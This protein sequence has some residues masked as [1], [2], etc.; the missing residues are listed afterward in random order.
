AS[1][2]FPSH[3][4]L[5]S[6]TKISSTMSAAGG[7]TPTTSSPPFLK[8]KL[9][10]LIGIFSASLVLLCLA[11]FL[12]FRL[13]HLSRRRVK[14]SS[15][16]I[17]LV[18][19]E[20]N[21]KA[22]SIVDLEAAAA[23]PGKPSCTESSPVKNREQDEMPGGVNEL[24]SVEGWGRWYGLKELEKATRG[25]AAENVVGEGGYGVVYRGV[26]A[27]G[28]VVAVKNLL[29]NK[30]QAEKEFEVEVEAIGKVRHKNL[31]GLIGY[32]VNGPSRMLVYEYVDNGNLEQ[33]LHGV[34]APVSPLTWDIRMK[35]AIGTAKALAYLHEGLE[36]KV[37]HRDV[38][39]SN[40]LLDRKWNAKVSDFGLAKLLGGETSYV[41]T[42]VMGTFGYVS[43][44]YASTGMLNEGSDVYSFGV[45]LIEIITGRS[46]ID[47]SKPASEMN[48]VDWFKGM[49][50]RRRGEDLV[51]PL[52][53]V[54]PSPRALKRAL[55]VCLR[56]KQTRGET[57]FATPI[58]PEKRK[59][60]PPKKVQNHI[61]IHHIRKSYF[62]TLISSP[63]SK[64][65]EKS[66]HF[67]LRIRKS[68]TRSSKRKSIGVIDSTAMEEK[69]IARLESAVSRLESLSSSSGFASRDIGLDFDSLS[70]DASI[71]AFDDLIRQSFGRVSAA[72]EKIGGQVLEVTNVIGQALNVEKDLL[73]RIKQTKKPDMAGLGV[74]MRPLNE[75]IGE[76]HAMTEGKRSDFFNHFKTAADSLSALVWIAYT[77][78]DCGMSMPIAHVE[79]SWQMAEFYNNKI[80]VEYKSKDPNH[81]EWAKAVKELYLPGLKDYVKSYYPLGPVWSATGRSVASGPSAPAPP[82]APSASHFSAECSK[83]SSS[84]PKEGMAAVFQEI[85]SG[86]PV[87]EGLRKVTND[88]KSKNRADR[89][90]VV[91]TTEKGAAPSSSFGSSKKTGPPKFELQM[92]RKW[93][94]EN[95]IGNKNL[96]ISDCDAK[97]SV[98]MF[99][100][101]DS[102]LQVQGKVNNITLD[103]C[104]KTG[105]VF[106]DVVAAFE[107]VNCSGVEVQC[108]GSAPTISV[109]NTSGCQVYLSKNSLETS[110]TT[111]KSSEINVLVPG[112]EPD[113]DLVSRACFAAAVCASVQRRQIRNNT[114][115]PLWRVKIQLQKKAP[116]SNNKEQEEEEEEDSKIKSNSE[117]PKTQI[118]RQIT[119]LIPPLSAAFLLLLLLLH[120]FPFS[121]SQSFI[122][123]NYGQVAD[124]LPPP[125]ATAKLLQ[126]TTVQKVRLYGADP[127]II[128][129]LANTG[130]GIVIGA[131]NGDIPSLAADPNAAGQWV[132]SNVLAF[133]PASNIVLVT[134]GNEVLLSGDQ[135]LVSQLLPAMQNVQNALNAASI[136]GKVKVSTV[137]SMA[138]LGRSD[139]PSSGSFDP[140]FGDTMKALLQFQR[141]VG[142]PIAVNPYPFFAYQSDPRPETLAFCLF[143][144][145]AGRVDS[146]NGIKYM[147]MFDAQVDAVRSALNAMGFKDIDIL[148][149][150]TGWPYRGDPNEVGPSIEN[151]RAYNGNL[152][153]H[154]RSMAGTPL[155]PGKS[156][157][158]FLF[159]LFDEDLKPG[160]SS[161]R[162]FG[163]FKP[164]LSM[165]YDVGLAKT[166]NQQSP[167]SSSS[168]KTPSSGSTTPPATQWCVSKPGVSAAQLQASLDYAC[169]QGVDC[170]PLQPGGACF[171]PNTVEAHAAYAM[172]LYFQRS[173]KRPWN[174]DFSQTAALT[175]KNPSYNG[176]NYP[177]AST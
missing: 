80:L 166:S 123:V 23:D 155:M 105:V 24:T 17:P 95:Q 137:H 26:L 84:K 81:V 72:A 170:T 122:G 21:T 169:G 99:G 74:F 68:S 135:G 22:S 168:S 90:G 41:T 71:Q 110:I 139:P 27:D 65:E 100:C 78:K 161:E 126:S 73:V 174:C 172:N 117:L 159:A 145:N 42:R 158:T 129:S 127:T 3:S 45:L 98:Y 34:D 47:Y 52:I 92:G 144:P 175:S 89:T 97:Q 36:P 133:Y 112:A 70:S 128:K 141:T 109:D 102:V 5:Y 134:I 167:P 76:A 147:N 66:N 111:A 130:I 64:P 10:V 125:P 162:S 59:I 31:V 131:A 157:D 118:R 136:G 11:V 15:G 60:S 85:N 18:I 87:T 93:V 54:Q 12:C 9:C 106:T 16:S 50:A 116:N 154:L 7:S 153:A 33:W 51:D 165:T 103:K 94:V 40:I 149:A 114:G 1:V 160:P 151:A 46:P 108:Q 138:V 58:L 143:Q 163:L 176:C 53:E 62:L 37:V 140:K 156:V 96:V 4:S 77:G 120:H 119:M 57:T 101:K 124:N 177:G 56:P 121:N 8:L 104:T 2:F 28:S 79:E 30:G 39:S 152:I 63:K 44:D 49:V 150:E 69:L 13:N 25:F 29:N 75:V 32:C 43:P 107:L 61:S 164:D 82:P 148:V 35:I 115:L 113:G 83:A 6:A 173:E 19:S 20:I 14:H 88:M 55:L 142:S 38:K 48:L 146:G 86:K 91:A 67:H 171:E 132:N